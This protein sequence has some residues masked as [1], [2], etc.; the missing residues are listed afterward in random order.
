[1]EKKNQPDVVRGHINTIILSAL[2]EGDKYGYE[3]GKE[4]E[5]KTRGQY[6]LKEPTLYSSLKRLEKQGMISA[7][8]GDDEKTGGGR[9]KYYT[10]TEKGREIGEKSL[11]QW[12]YSRTLIDKLISEKEY[13]LD[14]APPELD[15]AKFPSPPKNEEPKVRKPLP[16]LLKPE[17]VEK[18]EEN[19]ERLQEIVDKLETESKSEEAPDPKA[20]SREESAATSA[21]TTDPQPAASEPSVMTVPEPAPEPV[22]P[23]PIVL[24]LS[25]EPPAP[26]RSEPEP[27]LAQPP[28][29]EAEE[30]TFN[31]FDLEA[32]PKPVNT[33]TETREQL[34]RYIRQ[35]DPD[36]QPQRPAYDREE[37]QMTE[38]ERTYKTRINKLFQSAKASSVREINEAEP[39]LQEMPP[40]PA[41]EPV[42]PSEPDRSLLPH[43]KGLSYDPELNEDDFKE[44]FKIKVYQPNLAKGYKQQIYRNRLLCATLWLL[45]AVMVLEL[46]LVYLFGESTIQLG[47]PVYGYIAAALLIFPIAGTVIFLV[48]PNQRSSARRRSSEWMINALLMFVFFA[49]AVLAVNLVAKTVFDNPPQLITYV[50]LPIL[51]SFDIVVGTVL[52]I[53]LHRSGRFYV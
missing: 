29:A 30:R 39:P 22:R 7:Y 25:P 40:E 23:E 24:R 28:R 20:D 50:I 35:S 4:I 16:P 9:R 53:L 46:L 32:M 51:L 45:Y 36:P 49:L 17:Q 44:D 13:D 31:N 5:A 21:M 43:E 47:L 33:F 14:E 10:L 38:A 15:F 27:S 18:L 48:A 11:T 3:I 6:K 34:E 19:V 8:Y 1:M 2:C 41:P 12:E 42:R 52:Y 26:V 37:K